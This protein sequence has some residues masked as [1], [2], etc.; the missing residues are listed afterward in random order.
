MFSI[1]TPILNWMNVLIIDKLKQE[2]IVFDLNII[3]F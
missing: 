2:E 3:I 1:L